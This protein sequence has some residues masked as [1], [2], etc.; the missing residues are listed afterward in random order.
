VADNSG[1]GL[2]RT[3]T[4]LPDQ[5][6]Y[7]IHVCRATVSSPRPRRGLYRLPW[8]PFTASPGFD[9]WVS[10]KS[11][12]NGSGCSSSLYAYCAVCSRELLPS[13]ERVVEYEMLVIGEDGHP[14]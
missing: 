7:R 10:E 4:K 8:L 14:G 3:A 12:W 1:E 11:V 2:T 5:H 9:S 13:A 6:W